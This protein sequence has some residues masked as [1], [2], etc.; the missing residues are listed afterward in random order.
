[1]YAHVYAL[2]SLQL[3]LFLYLQVANGLLRTSGQ[4]K[5]ESKAKY[6]VNVFHEGEAVI[7]LLSHLDM[8][9]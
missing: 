2:K 9:M 6:A 1:M 4:F 8:H 3:F 5:I 7:Q